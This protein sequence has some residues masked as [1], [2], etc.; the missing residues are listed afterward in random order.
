MHNVMPQMKK[1]QARIL[2]APNRQAGQA[3]SE[4]YARLMKTNK[5]SPFGPLGPMIVQGSCFASMFFGLRGM[6]NQPVVSMQS[7]GLFWFTDL[8]AAD[9]LFVLPVVTAGSL[10]LFIY[11]NAEIDAGAMGQTVRKFMLLLP[12]LSI[13]AMCYFPAAL[14]L[15]WLT[16]NLLTIGQATLIK[17]PVVRNRFGI[18]ARRVYTKEEAELVAQFLPVSAKS[19]KPAHLSPNEGKVQDFSDIER[20]VKTSQAERRRKRS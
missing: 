11:S 15:Y 8:T 13:P 16:N 17:L 18:P 6:A 10:F 7:Q 2:A 1:A 5:V 12:I 20:R 3:A 19:D 14:N 9:P 4:D